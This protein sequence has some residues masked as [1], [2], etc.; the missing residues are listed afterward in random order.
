MNE[1]PLRDIHLPDPI[2]WWPLAIGWWLAFGI[3][4]FLIL[5]TWLILKKWFQ[6]TL[7]KEATI[8][9]DLIEAHFHQTEDP[10]RCLTDLS[11]FLRRVILSQKKYPR[12]SA[13]LTGQAW[14]KLLDQQLDKPEF[15]QGIGQVLGL[16]P[17]QSRAEKE[18]ISQIIQLCRRWV[19]SL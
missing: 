13:G 5:F 19:K 10:V 2:S 4:L 7:R 3:A 12:G 16:G 18:S 9:L 6:P 11:V 1:L 15:S 17:Y 8:T 14:L